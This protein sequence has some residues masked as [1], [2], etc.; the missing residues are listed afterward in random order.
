VPSVS[1]TDTL[2]YA[3]IVENAS[4]ADE[5]IRTLKTDERVPL[6]ERVITIQTDAFDWNCS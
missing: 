1:R 4:E 2:G 6:P 5:L 3:G